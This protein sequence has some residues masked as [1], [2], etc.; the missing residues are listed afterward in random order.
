MVDKKTH[1]V[2]KSTELVTNDKDRNEIFLENASL[3]CDEVKLDQKNTDRLQD[4]EYEN[5]DEIE[6]VMAR[7][8]VPDDFHTNKTS[9]NKTAK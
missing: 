7:A 1:H 3:S 5:D 8:P 6:S 2:D 4:E 9:I